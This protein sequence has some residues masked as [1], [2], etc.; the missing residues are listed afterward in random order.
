[1]GDGP[2]VVFVHGVSNS[3]A[4]WAPLVGRL[5]GL[6]CVVLDRPG[7][8]LSDRLPNR[9]DD[10]DQL[11]GFADGLIVDVLDALQLEAAHVVATS[12][13][14]YFALHAAAAHPDRIA[15]IVEFGWPVGAPIGRLPLIMRLVSVPGVG[16]LL[17]AVPPNERVVLS[18]FRRIG[19]RQALDAGRVTQETIELYLA[20]LRDTD[21]MRNELDSGPRMIG[22]LRGLNHAMLLPANLLAR[23]QAPV[24]FLWGEEDPFGGA[25]IARAFVQ[26]IPKAELE[27]VPGAGHA[28]WIDDPDA[29]AAATGGFFHG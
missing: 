3:G 29:A 17:A 2:A 14:G 8:G 7:C 5:A 13:G 25:A 9:L 26:Q 19:L 1:V 6:H 28:L 11:A 12:F 16:R 18:M 22:P 27:L 4:S 20:L 24:R 21:T 23:V 10:V 15:R